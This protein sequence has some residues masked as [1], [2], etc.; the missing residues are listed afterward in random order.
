MSTSSQGSPTHYDATQNIDPELIRC[1]DM[2]EERIQPLSIAVDPTYLDTVVRE[3][4]QEEIQVLRQDVVA[5]VTSQ[6]TSNVAI[7][8]TQCMSDIVAQKLNDKF[9]NE[10]S[11]S[12]K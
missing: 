11:A 10:L 4:V 8:V 3:G 9:I 12:K 1:L 7:D 2:I 6:V 5:D